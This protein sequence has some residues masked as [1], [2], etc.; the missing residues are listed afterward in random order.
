MKKMVSVLMAL[1]LALGVCC[2]AF[3]ESAALPA[4]TFRGGDPVSTAVV[5]YLQETD[6]GYET[7]EGGI[8]VPTPIILKTEVT[9]ENNGEPV[10]ANVYGNFWIFTYSLDGKALRTGPCGENPGVLKLAKQ[11]GEWTVVSAE[12]VEDGDNYEENIRKFANGDKDL[13]DAYYL[14]TGSSEESVLPQYQRA[15]LV[16]Y[17]NENNLDITAFQDYGQ[18]PVDLT[19]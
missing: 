10:E 16:N 11:N 9:A 6:L 1:A 17:V 12:F 13:E 19:N 7:P 5:K 4:Y 18:E 15:V 3:A 2:C 14:T 8:L